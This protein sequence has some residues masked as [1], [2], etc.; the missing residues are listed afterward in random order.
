MSGKPI[1][2]FMTVFQLQVYNNAT[3]YCDSLYANSRIGQM[4]S[5]VLTFN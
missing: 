4:K 3:V 2:L 1:H 5:V